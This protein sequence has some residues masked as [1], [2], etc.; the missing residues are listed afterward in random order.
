M[1]IREKTLKENGA[2]YTILMDGN[3]SFDEAISLFAD[4]KYPENDAYLVVA[5]PNEQYHVILF[6]DLKQ[7][8][9][10][11]MGSESLKQSLSGL[12]IPPA[13]R[14]IPT[15]TTESGGEIL[16]WV[17]SHPQSTVVI[18]DAGKFTGLFINPNRSGNLGLLD[19]LSLLELHGRL[20]QLSEDPRADYV[21]QVPLPTCP[22]CSQQNFYKF[23]IE[24][25]VFIC[26]SC[27][28]TVE[29]L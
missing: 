4:R 14:V 1:A 20:V 23:N 17:A 9:L 25:K 8:V 2:E 21:P 11:M 3:Q 15:D 28:G 12:P 29:Q 10:G 18:T 5:L 7:R 26:P 24:R 6:S 19:N 16:D 22:H 27:E 13:S